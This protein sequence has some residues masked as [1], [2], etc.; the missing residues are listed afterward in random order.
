MS[1]LSHKLL[2]AAAGAGGT[3]IADVFS[4]DL[5]TGNGAS[6]SI[7]NGLD[8]TGEG[9]LVWIKDRE[10][11]EN[12]Q[13]F[14]T[15]RD[16]VSGSHPVWETNRADA[17]AAVA[18]GMTFN[19]DGFSVGSNSRVNQ[20]GRNYA[21]WSMRK[22]PGFL[23]IIEYDGD[24]V[25]GRQLAHSLEAAPGMIWFK[26]L[27]QNYVHGLVWHRALAGSNYYLNPT[28]GNAES[29]NWGYLS[30]TAPTD[31][32]IALTATNFT[33][34]SGQK[35]VAYVFGHDESPQGLI[36]CGTYSGNNSFTGPIIDLG[37]KTQFVVSKSRSQHGRDWNL[38]DDER[39]TANPRR[40]Y[41]TPNGTNVENSAGTG[42]LGYNFLPVGFQPSGPH[43]RNNG[44]G[45][46]YMYWAIRAEGV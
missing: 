10:S 46:S 39:D 11:Y 15:E 1:A 12:W 43:N 40:R 16:L 2:M 31:T 3:S 30:T 36:Q 38:L 29:N 6:Q 5:Y 34:Q 22:A 17:Q 14:D 4:T 42:N 44:S 41:L 9:G 13:I 35:Y 28:S 7:A 23:D 18:N 20:T 33:N 26:N 21:A 32:H 19:S 27:S 8:L 45:E 24:G 37:W 25:S